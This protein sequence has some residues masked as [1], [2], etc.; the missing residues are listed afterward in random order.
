M[1]IVPVLFQL[2]VCN[3]SSSLTVRT[4][5]VGK[6]FT[7]VELFGREM[8]LKRDDQ[9]FHLSGLNGNKGRKMSNILE[10]NSFSSLASIGGVQSNSLLALSKI[11]KFKGLKLSYICNKVPDGLKK[12]PTGNYKLALELDTMVCLRLIS[13]LHSIAF[14]NDNVPYL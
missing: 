11:A 4:S 13:F 1:F 2:I 3:M 12:N 10:F 9:Q 14:T 8:Y 5:L 6:T 7:K